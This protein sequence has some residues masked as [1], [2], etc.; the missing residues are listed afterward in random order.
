MTRIGKLDRRAHPEPDEERPDLERAYEAP[1]TPVE[2]TLVGVWEEMLGLER[3]GIHDDF[4][5]LGGHS[6]LATRVISRVRDAFQ[7]EL[8]L[9]SLFEEPTVAGTASRIETARWAAQGLQAPPTTTTGEDRQ[10]LEL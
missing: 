6:L 5:E 1:R 4:F 2:E 9:R 8:P 3:V 7:V 10:G